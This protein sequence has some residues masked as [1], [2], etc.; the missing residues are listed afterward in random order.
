MEH[1]LHSI[2]NSHYC[3]I[4]YPYIHQQGARPARIANE[5]ALELNANFSE[6]LGLFPDAEKTLLDTDAEVK[7]VGLMFPPQERIHRRD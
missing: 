2:N 4:F 1:H 6:V 3:S 7:L 5:P